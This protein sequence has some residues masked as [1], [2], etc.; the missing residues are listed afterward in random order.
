METILPSLTWVIIDVLTT[1]LFFKIYV[2][3]SVLPA[4]IYVQHAY[5]WCLQSPEEN[6]GSPGSGIDE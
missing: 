3:K 6:A 2:Y 5:V 1:I 4:C